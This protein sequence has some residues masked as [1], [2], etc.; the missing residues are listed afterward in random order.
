MENTSEEEY[1]KELSKNLIQYLSN[2]IDG[3]NATI[4]DV[5][6]IDYEVE[7]ITAELNIIWVF[8]GEYTESS[9]AGGSYI[10]ESCNSIYELEN[11][12]DKLIEKAKFDKNLRIPFISTF[13][14]LERDGISKA[15]EN[16]LIKDFGNFSTKETCHTCNG[17]CKITCNSCGGNGKH[18]CNSCGGTGRSTQ[19]RY[20]TYTKRQESY[21]TSCSNCNGRGTRTCSS[22][23]GTGKVRCNN[24]K[25]HGF[26]VITRH[27]VAKT[28]P[29]FFIK[30]NSVLINEELQLY[31]NKKDIL[32]LN[33]SIYFEPSNE[34]V[35]IKKDEEEVFTYYGESVVIKQNFS[36]KIKEYICYAFSNPPIPFI[37]PTIFD[38]LF[39]NE[40]EFLNSKEGQKKY[41]SKKNALNFF[42]SYTKL[43][44]LDK[45][46]KEIA[47]VR[48]KSKENTTDS[49]IK[50]T[51]GFISSNIASTLSNHINKF[52]DKVSPSYSPSIWVI[53][54]L[55][56]SIINIVFFEYT[57][58]KKGTNVIFEPLFTFIITSITIALIIYPINLLIVYFKRR[59]IP[60]EYRQKLR[61]KEP[62]KLYMIGAS[63][64]FILASGYGI[65]SN[66]G[67]LPKTNGVPQ[68]ILFDSVNKGCTF[69]QEKDLDICQRI[70]LHEMINKL[71]AMQKR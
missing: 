5:K 3:N 8:F 63:V 21:S 15:N 52:M 13:K 70:G 65:L 57:F 47:S 14:E 51:Q 62:F 54:L 32:F 27:I 17:K 20:N 49:V 71:P 6:S 56:L 26:F 18:R 9:K 22:C 25:G 45:A 7:N 35:H 61:Y 44:I 37:K 55:I 23:S 64:I 11:I 30:T 50:A 1:D 66:K 53:G 58:E 28:K 41:I 68:H 48:E 4:N 34:K 31:L 38:D 67:Y 60:L 42:D 16:Y 40:I 12:T 39:I 19:Y 29:N 36:V 10:G 33:E 43:P 2:I 46:I 59:R 24:C 69:F